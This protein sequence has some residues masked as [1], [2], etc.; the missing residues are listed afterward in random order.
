MKE[1][2]DNL[3]KK[4]NELLLLKDMIEDTKVTLT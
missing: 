2:N 3:I 1:M 4:N